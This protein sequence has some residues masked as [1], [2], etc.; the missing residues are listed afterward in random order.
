MEQASQSATETASQPKSPRLVLEAG[1]YG[2][3]LLVVLALGLVNL[4]YPFGADQAVFFYGA[5]E[6][7]RGAR[8]YLEYWD[9]KQPGLY[10][11][12][13][14]A[15]RLFGFTEQGIHLLELIW[16]LAFSAVMMIILRPCLQMPWLSAVA[17]A[18]TVGIYYATSSEYELTQLEMMVAFPLLLTAF[19]AVRAIEVTR[20]GPAPA[21]V[22]MLFFIGG[23][24][25]GFATVFKLLLAPIAV[26]FWLVA[27]VYLLRARQ[28][29]LP[30]LVLQGAL[31]TA[32]G[33][34][35]PLAAVVFWFW[36]EGT[37]QEMLW[38][39][40]TY[41]P[42]ALT[43]SPPA[44]RTRLLSSTAFFAE[45]TLPWLLFACVAAATW[46][47]RAGRG[48]NGPFVAMML[49]W[50]LVA[51]GLFIIQRFSWWEYHMLL[52]F[53]PF[54]LL[55]VFGID[56]V[57]SYLARFVDFGAAARRSWYSHPVLPAMLA[58]ALIAIPVTASLT[59][60]LLKKAR[61]MLI[62]FQMMRDGVREYHWDVS[63]DYKRLWE[64]TRFL[65]MPEARPG[66]IYSFGSALVYKF[67]DR[68]SAHETAGSAWEFYLPSQTRDILATLDE[69]EVPYVLVDRND[70]KLFR[71]RPEIVAYLNRNYMRMAK[72][73]SGIWFERRKTALPGDIDP[74]PP[75]PDR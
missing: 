11:F 73:E 8:L 15:G 57:A 13:L 19:C 29:G 18:A 61:P 65:T 36:R 40:F 67:T 62:G 30:G 23:L 68:K 52:L 44:S 54:G 1:W 34:A 45:N 6:M 41:P 22:A 43:T 66:P 60:P 35:L 72:H 2:A 70:T 32:I 48:K 21:K 47:A 39:A 4:Y 14:F 20:E 75:S 28:I 31:P 51:G 7:D 56:T 58:A 63:E 71:L 25:A 3:G 10:Y 42:E 38:T 59:N 17:P 74:P 53:T 46:L 49:A 50:F 16:M 27:A 5:Q 12:Y 55:A 37:L 69:K 9:N 26:V 64:G 33:V 24:C